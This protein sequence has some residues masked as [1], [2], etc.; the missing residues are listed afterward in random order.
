MMSDFWPAWA[1]LIAGGD[2]TPNCV[3]TS[4]QGLP[5]PRGRISKL[6]IKRGDPRVI[7]VVPSAAYETLRIDAAEERVTVNELCRRRSL[8]VMLPGGVSA[9]VPRG[10]G[11]PK[12]PRELT[13]EY[14]GEASQ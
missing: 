6:G 4:N 8:G 3:D 10:I 1:I 9:A 13:V 14:D 11:L 2:G 12:S 5:M 7:F